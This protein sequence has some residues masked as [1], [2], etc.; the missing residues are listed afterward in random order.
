VEVLVTGCLTLLEDKYIYI[1]RMNFVASMTVLFITF[2][3]IFF[4]SIF[5]IVYMIVYF[6]ASIQFCKL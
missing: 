5:I 6:Y 2:F 1:Y 4:D 3:H